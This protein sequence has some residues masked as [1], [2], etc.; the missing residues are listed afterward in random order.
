MTIYNKSSSKGYNLGVF[1]SN[2]Y[3]TMRAN[4]KH[5]SQA[6]L[7]CKLHISTVEPNFLADPTHGDRFVLNKSF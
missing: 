4:Y 5:L 6:H 1:V 2:D 3:L 7:K